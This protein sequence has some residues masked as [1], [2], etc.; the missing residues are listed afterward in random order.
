MYRYVG[1]M[2]V[3]LKLLLPFLATVAQALVVLPDGRHVHIIK[4]N[5][6][7]D[8]VGDFIVQ[9]V[10]QLANDAIAEKGYFSMSIGSG[11]TVKPLA[12]LAGGSVDFS[13]VHIFFGN[14]QTGIAESLG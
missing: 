13:K 4:N 1:E 8:S 7:L 12:L 5:V 6:V 14:E 3:L 11:T 2:M 9:R 10:E